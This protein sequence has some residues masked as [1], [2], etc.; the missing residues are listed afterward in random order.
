M[1]SGRKKLAPAASTGGK[2]NSF[3]SR[4]QAHRLLAMCLADKNCPGLPDGY[5]IVG[6]QFQTRVHETNTDDLKCLLED[7]YGKS[8]RVM[9]QMKRTM[10]ASSKDHAFKE[11]VGLAWLDFKGDDFRPGE[12]S[13]NIIYDVDSSR[14]MR[15][16]AELAEDAAKSLT[17][18]SWLRKATA[19]GFSNDAKRDALQA[20]QDVLKEYNGNEVTEDELH[21]FMQH[22]MFFPQNLD[23]DDTTE[24]KLHQQA[25]A[26]A[27]RVRGRPPLPSLDVWAKLIAVCVD[28]NGCSG[29]V[30]L[31]TVAR[32]IGEDLDHR[33]KAWVYADSTWTQTYDSNDVS[34]GDPVPVVRPAVAQVAVSTPALPSTD[35]LLLRAQATSLN[36]L[37]TK[38]L[39][40]VSD[41]IK[42]TR[43]ADALKLLNEIRSD[44]SGERLDSHQEARWYLMHGSCI[45]SLRD[46]VLTAADDFLRAA[47]LF[48]DDDKLA[49]ARVR[50]LL[51]KGEIEN[52]VNASQAALARFPDSLA[53]WIS[54]TNAR[55]ANGE[56]VSE[57]DIPATLQTKAAAYQMAAAGLRQADDIEAA[58]RVAMLALDKEDVSFFVREAV[59]RYALELASGSS[60][61]LA[62]R[63]GEREKMELLARAV[64]E[65]EPRKDRLWAAQTPRAVEAA[66][67]HLAYA[68]LVLGRPKE[69]LEVVFE[70]IANGIHADLLVRLR[71]EAL[72]DSGRE[73][74]ALSYGEELLQTMPLDALV[75]F[76]QTAANVDDDK[77]LNAA[78]NAGVSRL[79]EDTEGRLAETLRV[80]KWE[81]MLK[82][83][84]SGELAAELQEQN[85]Q[86]TGDVPAVVLG[87]RAHLAE[88]DPEGAE[89]YLVRALALVQKSQSSQDQ[90]WVAQL[91][92]QAKRYAEAASLY[93]KIVPAGG[94]SVL[95]ANLL[96][97]YIRI[98][99]RAKARALLQSFPQN[100]RQDRLTR[101]LAME[102]GQQVGDWELL[103]TLVQPQLADQGNLTKSQLFA[104]MVAAR[105]E[106]QTMEAVVASYPP[107]LEGPIREIAQIASAEFQH[108]QP[109]KALARLYRMRRLNMG[110]T[111]AAA[112]YYMTLVLAPANL[113]ELLHQPE[114]VEAG[115]AVR[116]TSK[117]AGSRWVTIDPPGFDD[118]PSSEEF[119]APG[120]AEAK[121]L[122]GRRLG[123]SF[124]VTDSVGTVHEL[125]IEQLLTAYQR[126]VMTANEALHSPV[127]P[128]RHIA[129]VKLD[130]IQGGELNTAPLLQQVKQRAEQSRKTFE[131]YGSSPLTLGL[132]A[133]SLG[134]GV[135]DLVRSWPADGPMLAVGGGQA[136]E[137]LKGLQALTSGRRLLVDLSALTELALVDQLAL[138]RADIR[139][140]VTS[141][142]K[143]AILER[144]AE[145]R[146]LSP[147]GVAVERAGQLG[148]VEFTPES[149]SR[150]IAFF[151]TLLDAIEQYC[152]VVPAYGPQQ[153]PENIVQLTT[154]LPDEEHSVLLAALEYDAVLLT[155]D[156]RFRQLAATYGI[157]SSWPQVFLHAKLGARLSPRE[158]SIAILKMFCS[159]RSFISLS[160]SDLMVMV[161]Q[162]T[163]W[164]DIGVNQLRAFLS[165]PDS[166]FASAWNVVREFLVGLYRRGNC[167]LGAVFEL[168]SY[169]LEGLLRHPHCPKNF[170]D[171]S[172]ETIAVDIAENHRYLIGFRQYADYSVA[173]LTRLMQTVKVKVTVLYCCMP[174]LVRHSRR[175][176]VNPFLEDAAPTGGTAAGNSSGQETTLNRS[177][178]GD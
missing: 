168:Y 72:R 38:R 24:A 147:A 117:D 165:R 93:E 14:P 13:F 144:M 153:P 69:A 95:H 56:R 41:E 108:A 98:G 138:L 111:D 40:R 96:T 31:Q 139:P 112:A 27:T 52:A 36:T 5:R 103:E 87:A 173:R 77:R 106:P 163:T 155:L 78:I 88:G 21:R 37:V 133:R 128:T 71:I 145:M 120:T 81:C 99:H 48:E 16:V 143:D 90:Y 137:R 101:Y 18:E 83:G 124:S 154:T 125:K 34:S 140:L 75:S 35:D 109:K 19:K 23:A 135:I 161:D 116:V 150:D 126:M 172:A 59:L 118:L 25:I 131:L 113:S 39:D 46:D 177:T 51:L 26:Q 141:S 123:E 28:L 57:A 121:S 29:E 136:K 119:V 67:T 174:P 114:V 176:A 63:T 20:V 53:V 7:G 76:A 12:D 94:M 175:G 152:E 107:V 105:R 84:K 148:I 92:L 80:F 86:T 142:C 115:T 122:L 74:E 159:H 32:F 3:E 156:N 6:L 54:A 61:H 129:A 100:W 44:L 64:Q 102:L 30:S 68:L 73:A 2:G 4:V 49:A 33:F 132:L 91:M 15:A 97:C 58:L 79:A 110:S 10:R 1:R 89:A 146:V 66:V 170:A 134:T 55:I 11:S 60:L 162:G 45:W 8:K 130:E 160:A 178:A 65:F 85:V 22:L 104:L 151:Q 164:M 62:Y 70:A 157:T 169:L 158:Y 82:Q 149:R 167:Q 42:A 43:F 127:A 17:T 171:E 47:D 9:L 166:E 50:G